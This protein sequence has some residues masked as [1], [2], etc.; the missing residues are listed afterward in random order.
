[1]AKKIIVETGLPYPKETQQYLDDSRI[2][3]GL[4]DTRFNDHLRTRPNV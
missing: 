3:F 4:Y 1:M 2:E